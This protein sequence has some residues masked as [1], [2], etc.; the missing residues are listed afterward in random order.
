METELVLL[1]TSIL[2]DYYR[3]K[4][5]TNSVFWNLVLPGRIFMVTAITIFE[6]YVGAK[7]EEIPFWD[8]FFHDFIVVNFHS[9]DAIL[10]SNLDK[11]LKKKRKQIDIPDLFIAAIAVRNNLL[12]AT[13]NKSHFER[14]DNLRLLEF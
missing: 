11:I 3:K 6:I 1:D 4:D 2:I 14:I 13:L 10:A 12:F 7:N 5:K 8:N 9:N